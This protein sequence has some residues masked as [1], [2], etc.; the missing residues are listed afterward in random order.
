MN[1]ATLDPGTLIDAMNLL[2][3]A[4]SPGFAADDAR[5]GDLVPRRTD[6]GRKVARGHLCPAG[7]KACGRAARAAELKVV[8]AGGVAVDGRARVVVLVQV[9]QTA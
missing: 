5:A 4:C 2:W 6:S 1:G 8:A 7:W 3:A 9:D